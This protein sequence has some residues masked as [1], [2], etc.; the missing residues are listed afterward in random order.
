VF[1]QLVASSKAQ[2]AKDWLEWQVAD[3]SRI[4]TQLL[5]KHIS[6]SE[7]WQEADQGKKEKYVRDFMASLKLN[8]QVFNE[9]TQNC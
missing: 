3:D 5:R 1:E 9:V 2:Q 8:E 7:W 4:E 6:E